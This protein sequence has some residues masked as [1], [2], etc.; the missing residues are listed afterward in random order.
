MKKSFAISAG[1]EGTAEA[2][3]IIIEEGGNAVD[4]AIAA[5]LASFVTEPCMSSA[6]GGGFAQ[7]HLPDGKIWLVDFF[8]Q[9]PLHKFDGGKADFYPIEVDFGEVR[10]VRLLNWPGKE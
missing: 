2:A 4:A 9:T 3:R 5:L 6:G 1:H 8:C 7:V 10:E